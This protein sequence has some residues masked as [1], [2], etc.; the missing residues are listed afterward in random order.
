VRSAPGIGRTFGLAQSVALAVDLDDGGGTLP[1]SLVRK[2]LK[3]RI[4]EGKRDI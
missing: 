2:L 3:A 1:A 4:A